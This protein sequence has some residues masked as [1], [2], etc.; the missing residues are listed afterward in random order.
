MGGQE[1]V[2]AVAVDEDVV[3]KDGDSRSRYRF[4][5]RR[6]L[7]GSKLDRYERVKL[8][9]AGRPTEEPARRFNFSSISTAAKK[10]M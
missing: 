3:L 4:K 1:P 9:G 10:I 7:E 2:H 6:H 5:R 8:L